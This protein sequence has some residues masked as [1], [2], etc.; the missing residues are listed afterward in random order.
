MVVNLDKV[1]DS[2]LLSPLSLK[3]GEDPP[4]LPSPTD[5]LEDLT[6]IIRAYNHVTEKLQVSHE[7]LKQQVVRLQQELASTDAQL[8]RSK[9]LAALGE[10]AAGIAHEIRNP[11]SAIHLYACMLV[12]DLT[13]ATTTPPDPQFQN[14]KRDRP[15]APDLAT[16][17]QTANKIA[18][19]VR[20]LNTIVN[21]VLSFSGQVV[22]RCSTMSLERLFDRV[23]ETQ[24]P[25]I[26]SAHVQVEPVCGSNLR[27]WADPLLLHQA[28]INLIRN[29]LDSMAG[30]PD[31]RRLS[32]GA[33]D[34]RTHVVFTVRDTG[35]GIR[36]QDIDRIFNPF[37][38]TRN[39]GTG[40]GLAIVH[41]LAVA[42]GGSICVH[43]DHGA[44]FEL[45]L[46]KR[47]DPEPL[48]PR[49]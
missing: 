22:P 10:M 43:N 32:L 31:P 49:D 40:L 15:S 2:E 21:D 47:D 39:S 25:V 3:D 13:A 12:E 26:D 29:A 23:L 42:H 37:F 6:Q 8:Q 30:Q 46:P 48:C 19:A 33:R 24:R 27:L 36:E 17:A 7:S 44:V 4:L 11:L 18:A 9:Q 35:P 14:P 5:R 20:S 28:L 1:A 34:E 41:R 38:T 16:S 45:S